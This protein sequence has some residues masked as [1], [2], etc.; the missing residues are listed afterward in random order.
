VRVTYDLERL[1]QE[2][3]RTVSWGAF[4]RG[5]NGSARGTATLSIMPNRSM[6]ANADLSWLRE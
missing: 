3:G 4:V 5:R 1:I 6:M 2:A